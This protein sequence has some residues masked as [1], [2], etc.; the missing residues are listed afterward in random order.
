MPYIDDLLKKEL[1]FEFVPVGATKFGVH[2]YIKKEDVLLKV[3]CVF[4]GSAVDCRTYVAERK[5]REDVRAEERAH[6]NPLLEQY[7]R[8]FVR[9]MTDGVLQ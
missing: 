4:V 9:R 5:A 1:R 8:R 3:G 2:E 6:R 7:D